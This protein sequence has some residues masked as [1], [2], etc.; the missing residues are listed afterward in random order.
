M[1]V[2]PPLPLHP[3]LQLIGA[4][5]E[6][7][8]MGAVEA[9]RLA[10]RAAPSAKR[11]RIGQTLR[12]G[13]ATPLWNTFAAALRSEL[14]KRGDQAKLARI[15]GVPRQRLH[16]MLKSNRQ[17]PDAER[18]LLLLTWLQARRAGKDLG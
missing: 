11:P 10:A 12:P 6:G 8:V 7:L 9:A 3:H 18:T 15:V 16:E 14:K 13:P 2:D 5:A 17:M 1:K 4:L